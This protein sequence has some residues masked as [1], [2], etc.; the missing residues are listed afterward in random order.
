MRLQDTRV[1]LLQRLRED[2]EEL[3][4]SDF[5]YMYEQAVIGYACKLGLSPDAAYDVL[6][7][8][9]VTLARNLKN[10]EYDASR[11]KFR[12][13]LLTIVHRSCLKAFRRQSRRRE[14]QASTLDESGKA[15]IEQ[16][17]DSKEPEQDVDTRKWQQAL[18]EQALAHVAKDE[19]TRAETVEI[20]EAYVLRGMSAKEVAEKFGVKENAVY[21]IKARLID[22]LQGEV[23]LLLE[24]QIDE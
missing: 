5:F 12:N 11:G 14:I 19:S 22:R 7:E 20:F 24:D 17:A 23:A 15:W 8:T 2:D 21:Q 16:L 13:Y 9:M 18:F 10:F 6:Q 1:S 4:W 3:D